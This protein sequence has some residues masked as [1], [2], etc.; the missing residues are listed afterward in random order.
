[1]ALFAIDC[2]SAILLFDGGASRGGKS[3]HAAAVAWM[4]PLLLEWD[5]SEALP[6]P[7]GPMP[8]WPF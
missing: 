2:A 8:V 3:V 1:M 7:A 6:E 5:I 4:E